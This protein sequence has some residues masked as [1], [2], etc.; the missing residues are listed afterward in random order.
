[1]GSLLGWLRSR[2]ANVHRGKVQRVIKD[3]GSSKSKRRS[4]AAIWIWSRRGKGFTPEER[5]QCVRALTPVAAADS[6]P[7]TRA[8]AIAALVALEAPGAADLVLEALSDPDCG[9]RMIVAGELGP[10]N[11][12]RVVDALVRLLEDEDGYVRDSAALGLEMQ[13]DP[14]ALGPLRA[15]VEKE[16]DV[17]ARK[18]ALR[19]IRVLERQ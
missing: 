8:Q 5:S 6:D 4:D 14:R 9:V 3:L 17:A 1:M 12:P 18:D 13:G 7:A 2:R 15:M 16:R 19:A 10:T 11:D